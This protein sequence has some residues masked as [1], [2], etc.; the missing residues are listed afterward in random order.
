VAAGIEALY[1]ARVDTL[2]PDS[3]ELPWVVEFHVAWQFVRIEILF[4]LR[5]NIMNVFL[6]TLISIISLGIM[7]LQSMKIYSC[8]S[9]SKLRGGAR[10]GAPTTTMDF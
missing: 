2:S 6:N 7:E 10:F 8:K 9:K 4:F 3:G 5:K 1:L